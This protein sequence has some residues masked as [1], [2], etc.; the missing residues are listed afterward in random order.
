MGESGNVDD[1]TKTIFHR[2]FAHFKS[3]SPKPVSEVVR[4]AG[5]AFLTPFMFS[6]NTGHFLS[7]MRGRS[8]TKTGTPLPWYTYPSI[9]FLSHRSFSDK[10]IIEFGRG[11]STTW[12]AKRASKVITF[13]SDHAW[14]KRIRYTSPTNVDLHLVSANDP[15]A[16]VQGVSQVLNKEPDQRYDVIVIDGLHRRELVPVACEFLAED[17]AIICDNAEGYGFYEEFKNKHFQRVDF[18]GYAPGAISPHTTSLFFPV[19][20]FLFDP[21]H[22]I[23]D[24]TG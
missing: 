1:V 19:Q 23:L 21:K 5:T 22:P 15:H 6:W 9:S 7:S 20:C 12:W 18:F 8:V 10:T 14:L 4:R 3:Y 2:I 13:E 17:G 16:C 24:A 11:Q